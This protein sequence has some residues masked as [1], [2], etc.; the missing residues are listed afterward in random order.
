MNPIEFTYQLA[1]LFGTFPRQSDVEH[2][3]QSALVSSMNSAV[4]GNIVKGP[5]SNALVFLDLDGDNQ[6]VH[7]KIALKKNQYI[8]Y[9]WLHDVAN[10]IINI[11]GKIKR[12]KIIFTSKY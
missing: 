10:V 2:K 6:L 9:N 7:E 4:S 5:L 1:V 12:L 11:S 3:K 8:K